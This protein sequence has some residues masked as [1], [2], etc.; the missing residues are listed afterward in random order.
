MEPRQT[1]CATCGQRI[2][3]FWQLAHH[4]DC[5][6]LEPPAPELQPG[7]ALAVGEEEG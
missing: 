5:K 3:H 7:V 1:T 2:E 6:P 4:F